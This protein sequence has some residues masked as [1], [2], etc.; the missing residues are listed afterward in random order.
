MQWLFSASGANA[1]VAY[2]L[3]N[4]DASEFTAACALR[5]RQVSVT[6]TRSADEL[7]PGGTVPVNI[8]AGAFSRAYTATGSQVSELDGISH[9]L[10]RMS[11]ADPLWAALIK[12]K[13]VTFAI[14]SSA[15][16]ALSLAGSSAQVKQFLAACSPP[17]PVPSPPM[18]MQ[19]P[20]E[21]LPPPQNLPP[22]RPGPAAAAIGYACD[23]GSYISVAFS[24]DTAAVYDQ[25]SAPVVLFA[26]PSSQ[27]SRWIAG[28][29]QLV[30]FGEQV[31][32]TERGYTR[33][34]RRG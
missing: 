30:G 15:P 11:V 8:T 32:W 14:G 18:V 24:G 12:E 28:Q 2:A 16:Y 5:S 9:P 21:I 31:Y 6:L 13:T 33:A 17:A 26:A 7:G 23:D 34:C 25:G 10:I 3:P 20:S 22:P 27:G 19:E 1:T 29:S 4:T